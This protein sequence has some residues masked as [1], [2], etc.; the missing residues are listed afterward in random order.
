M[1]RAAR[2]WGTDSIVIND[3]LGEAG[4]TPLYIGLPS[5]R[6]LVDGNLMFFPTCRGAPFWELWQTYMIE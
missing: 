5:A 2:H 4:R 3:P 6:G 1:P